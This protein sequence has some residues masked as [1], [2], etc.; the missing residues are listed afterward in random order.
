MAKDVEN[1]AA[2]VS[3]GEARA[4]VTK[5]VHTPVL[6]E[7]LLVE[8]L[9]GGSVRWTC[10]RAEGHRRP[11]DPQ[12]KVGDP[13]YW[14]MS[15]TNGAQRVQLLTINWEES[16]A[17]PLLG[18]DFQ[19]QALG[20][21]VARPDVEAMLEDFRRPDAPKPTPKRR[22]GPQGKR[23]G[24]AALMLWGGGVPPADIQDNDLVDEIVKK[25]EEIE[26]RRPADKRRSAPV[27][28]TILAFFG[29]LPSR[30]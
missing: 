10:L 13:A 19:Y 11:H 21:M 16:I 4:L 8:R 20:V 12:F 14:R 1:V 30:L 25:L 28:T 17:R 18:H 23:I 27:H 2:W 7:R 26:K 29:R 3:L 24:G 5:V 15:A 6:A 22:P 9:F